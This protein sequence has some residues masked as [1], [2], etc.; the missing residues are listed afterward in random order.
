MTTDSKGPLSVNGWLKIIESSPPKFHCPISNSHLQSPCQNRGCVLWSY[1]PRLYNCAGAF[2]SAK[3]ANAEERLKQTSAA[4]KDKKG[5]LRQAAEGKLS[6]FDL[7]HFFALSRQRVEGYVSTGKAMSEVLEPLF[8]APVDSEPT[9]RIGSAMRFTSSSS[10]PTKDGTRV[11][12]CCEKR[13]ASDDA[14]MVMALLDRSEVAWCSHDCV[15]EF[16]LDAYLVANRYKRH[17]TDVA[18]A[19]ET[20]DERSRVREVTPE[21]METLRVLAVDQ[22]YT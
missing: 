17:W 7:A 21:R 15:N 22:G 20:I 12:V 5:T 14:G 18:I 13:I 11:C 9:R 8:H 10:V 19:K 2:A 4:S 6:F 16:P 3:A 1:S